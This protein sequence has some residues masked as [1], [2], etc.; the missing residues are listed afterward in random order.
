MF[1]QS[2]VST[3]QPDGDHLKSWV[4]VQVQANFVCLWCDNKVD[5]TQE[6]VDE[7]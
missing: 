6:F 4:L 1:I 2:L 5:Q 3:K 7:F